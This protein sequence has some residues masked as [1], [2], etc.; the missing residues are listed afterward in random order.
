M[1]R[2]WQSQKGITSG[3]GIG[4]KGRRCLLVSEWRRRRERGGNSHPYNT[5]ESEK[6]TARSYR[7]EGDNK[8]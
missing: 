5:N 8:D 6:L 4:K 2:E 3:E 7:K 1:G